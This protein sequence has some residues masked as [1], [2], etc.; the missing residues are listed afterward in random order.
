MLDHDVPFLNW[1]GA[2]LVEWG[3]EHAVLALPVAP[4]HL[5][6]SG[7]VHGG[8]YSV[9]ADAA[10]GLAGCYGDGPG[11]R[12]KSY[13]MALTTS[14]L[15]S[16]RDGRLVARGSLRRRGRLVYF[17]TVEITDAGGALLALA[18]GNFLIRSAAAAGG[19]PEGAA[20]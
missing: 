20:E 15:G 12:V 19:T 13:T 5:N 18:E 7:V 10:G 4:Q 3:P 17:A 1:L 9:L 14:F 16:A 6:R 11:A 2:T 8:V